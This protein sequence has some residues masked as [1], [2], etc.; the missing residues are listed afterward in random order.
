MI[1]FTKSLFTSH[2][3]AP[4]AFSYYIHAHNLLM[5]PLLLVFIHSFLL[6]TSLLALEPSATPLHL[7]I[8]A[9]QAS[10]LNV[11]EDSLFKKT[12]LSG[13]KEIMQTA[14]PKNRTINIVFHGHSVPAG[15]FVT[16]DVKTFSSYPILV[17]MALNNRYPL[18]VLNVMNTAIGGEN[19]EK[20]A[21]RFKEDVLKKNPDIIFIDYALNDRGMGLD[22]AKTNWEKMIRSAMKRKIRI[23]LLTPTPDKREDITSADAV[24]EKHAQQIRQLAKKYQIALIDSYALFKKEIDKGVKLDELMSQVNHP[25]REGH[26]LVANEILTWF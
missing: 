9:P 11:N 22:K 6:C 5:K 7:H 20:G 23:F 17:H 19:S 12:Y 16:P 4:K 3:L 10:T 21:R 24:L 26:M 13:I 25:N 2:T 8:S 1:C 18:S 15:Y 14:W